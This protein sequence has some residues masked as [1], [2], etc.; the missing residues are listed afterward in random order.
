MV[1]CVV[2]TIGEGIWTREKRAQ[3]RWFRGRSH[4]TRQKST[5]QRQV[6]NPRPQHI[7]WKY[8]NFNVQHVMHN[9]QARLTAASGIDKLSIA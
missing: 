8:Y 3:S 9:Q 5:R 6:D 7:S 4:G 1:I 2:D